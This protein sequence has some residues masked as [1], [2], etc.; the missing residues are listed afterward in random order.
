MQLQVLKAAMRS[1]L[2]LGVLFSVNFLLSASQN[3][4][5]NFLTYFVV[6]AI[7][8]VTYRLTI[9]FREGA[10]LGYISYGRSFLFILMSFFYAALI[11][12]LVKFI[13]FQI[14]PAYLSNLYNEMML[15]VESLNLPVEQEMEEA[16]SQV[17]R[18]AS[19]AIQYIWA[20]MLLGVFVA[21][22]MS[23]FTRK[24]KSIFEE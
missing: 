21:L 15:L 20:N 14:N 16:L 11:S 19:F 1:G 6:V 8:V 7:V 10:C 3:S 9:Q 4:V 23:A 5:L 17:L 24:E 12:S 2:I 22:I 18:P 13:Y